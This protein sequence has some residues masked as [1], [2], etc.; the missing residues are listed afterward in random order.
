MSWAETAGG[1]EAA[2]AGANDAVDDRLGADGAA[3]NAADAREDSDDCPVADLDGRTPA[4][5]ATVN[6]KRF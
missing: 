3:D 1:T 5:S 6:A 2:G 4:R